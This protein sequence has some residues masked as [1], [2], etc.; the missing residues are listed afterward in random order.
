[1]TDLLKERSK[2]L[3]KGTPALGKA[4]VEKLLAQVPGYELSSDGKRIT[5]PGMWVIVHAY[6]TQP[7]DLRTARAVHLLRAGA[8]LSSMRVFLGLRQT[9][10]VEHY[11]K[12]ADL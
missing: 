9:S 10:T 11:R 12:L 5:R 6:G 7:D 3:P 2:E 1:M 4:E 8:D